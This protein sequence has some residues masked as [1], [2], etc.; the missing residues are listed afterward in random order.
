MA[1][2]RQFPTSEMTPF[3]ID[4]RYDFRV[5]GYRDLRPWFDHVAEGE[6]IGEVWLT[7]DENLVATGPHAG[8]RLDA[9]FREAHE[10]LLGAGA[11]SP[12]SPL[13]IKVLF[14]KE[15][16][17]VQVHPDDKMAQK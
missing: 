1:A 4:P 11:P 8:K 6:P 12:A 5:W 17:S 10:A 3:R 16:L 9:L 14:A 13:L 15:K 7:G 2:S